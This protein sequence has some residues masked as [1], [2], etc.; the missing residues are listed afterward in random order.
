MR[1]DG[2]QDSS[3]RFLSPLASAQPTPGGGS[4]AALVGAVGAAL[5]C[6]VIRIYLSRRSATGAVRRR[7]NQDLLKLERILRRLHGLIRQ[8]AVVYAQFVKAL[9]SGRGLGQAKRRAIETPMA[10]CESVTQAGYI[11]KA[12][13]PFLGTHLGSDLKAATHFL[14]AA[15]RAAQAMVRVNQEWKPQHKS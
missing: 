7:M 8:D 15:F 14:R 11:L 1:K 9:A 6:K 12:V 3:S 13:A 5:G 2:S 4:A 10:I